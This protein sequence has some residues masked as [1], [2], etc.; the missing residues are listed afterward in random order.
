[1]AETP[2]GELPG[3][4]YE[5]YNNRRLREI[6]LVRVEAGMP[7]LKGN[8][9]S[10]AEIQAA[11]DA[12]EEFRT[13][14]RDMPQDD[15]RELAQPVDTAGIVRLLE[16]LQGNATSQTAIGLGEND[17]ERDLFLQQIQA[18]LEQL[19]GPGGGALGIG[20]GPAQ[21]PADRPVPEQ[22][23]TPVQVLQEFA[24]NNQGFAG[25]GQ[26]SLGPQGSAGSFDPEAL[27]LLLSQ[28]AGKSAT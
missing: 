9:E 20:V 27:I 14:D 26:T 13:R 12:S 25:G 23:Q 3:E 7:P 8:A 1:M 10:G 28:L 5:E 11:L 19:G 15:R 22:V 2:F 16:I 21:L 24:K 17:E 6:N 4:T 18:R